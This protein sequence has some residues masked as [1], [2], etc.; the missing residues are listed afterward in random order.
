MRNLLREE[1]KTLPSSLK[2]KESAILR[3]KLAQYISNH[4]PTGSIIATYAGLSFEP[5]LL[6]LHQ[7]LPDY[8]LAYPR[9]DSDRNMYFH[10]V[11]NPNNEKELVKGYYAIRE[12]ENH[13]HTLIKADQITLFILPAFAFTADGHRLGKGGGY[14]DKF[15]AQI[16][17]Q[18]P[19]IGACFSIQLVKE[20]PTE[21]HDISVDFVIS[22]I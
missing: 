7:L 15:L 14:Y 8:Q 3:K 19:L 9:C 20:I 4:C 17:D 13:R 18:T 1:L 10:K 6:G 21:D 16:S 22:P 12:P 2:T 11:T 5:D